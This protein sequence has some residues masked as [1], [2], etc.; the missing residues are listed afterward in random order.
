MG[1]PT[2]ATIS[3]LRTKNS[4]ATTTAKATNNTVY[5]LGGIDTWACKNCKIKADKHLFFS[6]LM[7]PLPLPHSQE[8]IYSF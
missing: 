8:I 3:A 6:S 7:Q 2:A 1:K 4:V 5:R